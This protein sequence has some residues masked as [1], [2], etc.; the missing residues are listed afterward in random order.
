[1]IHMAKK[2]MTKL[3]DWSAKRQSVPPGR[4]HDRQAQRREHQ[5]DGEQRPVEGREHAQEDQ[6]ETLQK[7]LRTTSEAMDST[8]ASG[9]ARSGRTILS[10]RSLASQ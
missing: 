8:E 4:M 10:R 7:R 9:S 2:A 5:Q 1:M 3:R 6:A